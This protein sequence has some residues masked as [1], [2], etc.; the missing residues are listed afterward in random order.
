MKHGIQTQLAK[1]T[2]KSISLINQILSG[3]K[4]PSPQ[5]AKI[6][7]TIYPE[8]DPFFWIDSTAGERRAVVESVDLVA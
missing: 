6:L 1:K 4:N 2:G 7:A 5:T 3:K 8:T